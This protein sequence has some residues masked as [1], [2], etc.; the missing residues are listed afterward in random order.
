MLHIDSK[1]GKLC[2]KTDEEYEAILYLLNEDLFYWE[3]MRPEVRIFIEHMT[4]E[5][6]NFI[7][8]LKKRLDS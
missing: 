5:E 2:P 3:Y 8:L 7:K 1:T 4:E 6:K